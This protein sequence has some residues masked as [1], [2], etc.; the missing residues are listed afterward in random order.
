MV[1]Q[2]IRLVRNEEFIFRK[3]AEEMILVPIHQDI[4]DMDCIY[5]LNEVGAHIWEQLEAPKTLPEL[6]Q[7]V[8]DAYE[9]P[10]ELIEKDIRDFVAQLSAFGAINEV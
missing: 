3:I 8:L 10:P 9:A 6:Q 4:V 1:D 5:S 2:E 7:S